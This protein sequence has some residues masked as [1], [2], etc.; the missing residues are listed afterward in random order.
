M[1][2][3]LLLGLLLIY[4]GNHRQLRSPFTLGL[5]FFAVLLLVQ[6][7]GAM[8]FYYAMN[9]AGQGASVAVPMFVLNTAEL[10]GFAA[11]FYV[12]WR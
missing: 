9:E 5:V 10:I 12:T 3:V 2:S 7:L 1:S 6:N 11:L 4:V 8:Y